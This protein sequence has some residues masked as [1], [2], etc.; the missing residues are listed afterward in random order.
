MW[1]H[2]FF[3]LAKSCLLIVVLLSLLA[4]LSSTTIGHDRTGRA[5]ITVS[6]A[7]CSRL[8]L[9]D[10]DTRHLVALRRTVASLER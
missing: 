3:L 5:V 2:G 1:G 8:S 10:D 7:E 4:L 6:P 9:G